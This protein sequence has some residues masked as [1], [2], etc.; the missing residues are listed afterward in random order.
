MDLYNWWRRIRWIDAIGTGGEARCTVL[1]WTS[2]VQFS[3]NGGR[4]GA[5][6]DGSLPSAG[7]FLVYAYQRVGRV[8]VLNGV[9]SP[10]HLNFPGPEGDAFGGSQ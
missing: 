5:G 8:S 3:R 10:A 4:G 2:T 7:A 9:F 1:F 6:F